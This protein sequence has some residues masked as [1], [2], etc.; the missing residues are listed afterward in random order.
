MFKTRE[1]KTISRADQSK[2]SGVAF[3]NKQKKGN[4]AKEPVS[5]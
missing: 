2:Y 5:L 1:K 3:P 4:L